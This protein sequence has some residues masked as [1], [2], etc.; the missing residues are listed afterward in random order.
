MGIDLRDEREYA[1][2]LVR[3]DTLTGEF[4]K[5]WRMIPVRAGSI[6][7]GMIG[8]PLRFL[9]L[10]GTLLLTAL[11]ML[12]ILIVA[13]QIPVTIFAYLHPFLAGWVWLTLL[14][15][16]GLSLAGYL[17]FSVGSWLQSAAQEDDLPGG[18]DSRSVTEGLGATGEPSA[19][20][21][22]SGK[23]STGEG[24]QHLA[25]AEDA[26][27]TWDRWQT[28][29]V[30]HESARNS[31]FGGLSV[32]IAVVLQCTAVVLGPQCF[33]GPVGTGWQWP[34]LFG[35]QLF[36][37]MLL[38]IPAGFLPT[39]AAIQPSAPLGQLLM[40]GVDLFYV[41]GV[42]AMTVLILSSAFKIRELFNGTTRDLADHL[43]NT[44][45]SGAKQ[46]MIHRVAV[47]RPLDETEVV[48]LT[49]EAFLE[50]TM[51]GSGRS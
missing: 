10:F 42:I 18:A 33:E 46:L 35:E 6:L 31:L 20:E 43:E 40:T 12:A 45:I 44:D 8:Y 28:L 51:S 16:V 32:G 2:L 11:I 9:T 34:F 7:S 3:S 36:N 30:N 14:A 48:S 26:P 22:Y 39:Y 1:W 5:V 19:G 47:L 25:P 38:G 50:R 29:H 27:G 23:P 37:P 17:L 49:K 21:P 15:A 13:A 24:S 4:I 41:S